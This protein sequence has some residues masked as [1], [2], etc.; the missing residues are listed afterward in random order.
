VAIT[1]SNVSAN[2]PEKQ[3]SKQIAVKTIE[4]NK[5][6]KQTNKK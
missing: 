6:N 4:K 1:Q 2:P 5:T 3:N